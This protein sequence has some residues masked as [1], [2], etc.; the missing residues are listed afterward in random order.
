MSGMTI[1]RRS[2]I[3]GVPFVAVAALL[4]PAVAAS[5]P[6]VIVYKGAT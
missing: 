6:T 2:L 3:A 4:P 5:L 1:S